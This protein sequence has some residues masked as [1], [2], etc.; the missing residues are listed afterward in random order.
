MSFKKRIQKFI[1]DAESAAKDLLTQPQAPVEPQCRSQ[2]EPVFVLHADDP[3]ASGLVR[4]WCMR[5]ERGGVGEGKVKGARAI[6]DKMDGGDPA[7]TFTL[8]GQDA[9]GIV[10]MW[11]QRATVRGYSAERIV[12]AQTIADAMAIYSPKKLPD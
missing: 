5:A 2:G 9:I 3:I 6:A 11:I 12:Q 7:I 10:Q 4:E 8:R 1:G